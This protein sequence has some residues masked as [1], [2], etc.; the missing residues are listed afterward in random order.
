MRFYR[1]H[2]MMKQGDV[3]KGIEITDIKSLLK[4]VIANFSKLDSTRFLINFKIFAPAGL[5]LELEA[6]AELGPGPG[7][8]VP[9]AST[10]NFS[11]P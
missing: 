8:R 4:L 7:R 3:F 5:E 11:S 9:L 2:T 10:V 1:L 6:D